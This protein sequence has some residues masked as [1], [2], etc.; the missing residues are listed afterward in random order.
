MLISKGLAN[1]VI[2]FLFLRIKFN[3]YQLDTSQFKKKISETHFESIVSW[4][5]SIIINVNTSKCVYSSACKFI[6]KARVFI[7]KHYRLRDETST[8]NFNE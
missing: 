2:F 7:I 6:S 8:G 3:I 4:N 1:S 5:G